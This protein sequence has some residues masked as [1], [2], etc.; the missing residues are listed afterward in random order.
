[1][2]ETNEQTEID[3]AD[4][5]GLQML[6]KLE[7]YTNDPDTKHIEEMEDLAN[8][9]ALF[10]RVV[11]EAVETQFATP[12]TFVREL[13]QNARDAY[14][15]EDD[16]DID[17]WFRDFED[18]T[19]LEVRDYG[20]GMTQEEVLGNL[21]IPYNSG[22]DVDPEK[23]GEHGIGWFS[24]L[25][26]ASTVEVYTGNADETNIVTVTETDESW[27]ANIDRYDEP[28]EGTRVMVDLDR[29]VSAL[30]LKETAQQNL[31]KTDP[32]SARITFDAEPIN[33][34]RGAF[35]QVTTATVDATRGSGEAELHVKEATYPDWIIYTQDGLHINED[36]SPFENELR[37]DIF[38]DLLKIG[39]QFWIELPETV[40]LTKGR[41]QV[42]ANDTAAVDEATVDAFD[43]FV[44]EN[45]LAT[46]EYDDGDLDLKVSDW[47]DDLMQDE[48]KERMIPGESFATR[49][50]YSALGGTYLAMHKT[51]RWLENDSFGVDHISLKGLSFDLG[52]MFSGYD[53][54]QSAEPDF[55][56]YYAEMASL[57][58][59]LM[60]K[61]IVDAEHV[62]D[63]LVDDETVSVEAMISAH[64]NESLYHQPINQGDGLYVDPGDQIASTVI[65]NLRELDRKHDRHVFGN[66]KKTVGTIYEEV[67]WITDAVKH[68]V[69]E[70][71]RQTDASDEYETMF[72][73]ART[74]QRTVSHAVDRYDQGDEYER[75]LDL[76]SQLD[77][78]VAATTD[79]SESQIALHYDPRDPDSSD[80]DPFETAHTLGNGISVNLAHPQTQKYVAAMREGEL[81]DRLAGS[82]TELYLH[83]KAHVAKDEDGCSTHG[84]GFYRKERGL[85]YDLAEEMMET[86]YDGVSFD[87]EP[88]DE[89][90]DPGAFAE[91]VH[92]YLHTPRGM[93]DRATRYL[94]E[95][96]RL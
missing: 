32:A 45:V 25:D 62:D 69:V 96:V 47:I 5:V 79:L 91:Q 94:P 24:A 20:T 72:S 19:W 52:N 8:D 34:D 16:R 74:G 58:K 55:D 54:E 84:R 61:A 49:A 64:V 63:G 88:L 22:K 28:F 59:Q 95:N 27:T 12:A 53:V 82:L 70:H 78:A 29:Y 89:E 21:L 44:L 46:D 37:A 68:S 80:P 75:L 50:M 10:E 11:K 3:V 77:E 14:D 36:I 42:V 85:G 71:D 65:E 92:H 17:F 57:S 26:V 35:D 33:T 60:Q 23:I 87:M 83:E 4:L 15:R 76:F 90:T 18:S 48:Y 93:V 7:D 1:M 31:G 67:K 86:D 66:V 6:G 43:A 39:Y 41:D 56:D 13:G 73:L 81:D 38:E 51:R 40:G 30:S 9:T 2:Q